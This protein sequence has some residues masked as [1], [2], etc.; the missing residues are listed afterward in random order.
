MKRTASL[1]LVLVAAA[2]IVSSRRTQPRANT[3]D[4]TFRFDA[5]SL[6]DTTNWTKVNAEPYRISSELDRLCGRPLTKEGFSKMYAEERKRNPHAA[7]YITVYVN[8][9]GRSA[10]FTKDSPSFPEGS[11][12]V[13]QKNEKYPYEENILLYTVMRKRERGYNPA[14]GDWE[15]NVVNADGSTV[16]A[17][18]KLE[19]CQACHVKNPSSDFVFRSYVDFK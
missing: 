3:V 16:A 7:T 15:F 4:D 2:A 19:N 12:I 17:S 6:T 13:K 10:M 5:R 11:V 8:A 1:L 9:V 18:G 14:V